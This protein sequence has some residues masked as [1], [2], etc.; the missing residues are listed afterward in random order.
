MKNEPKYFH[1]NE[2]LVIT[3]NESIET[4][5]Q[6]LQN[7]AEFEKEYQ[8]DDRPEPQPKKTNVFLVLSEGVVCIGGGEIFSKEKKST[9]RKRF[10]VCTPSGVPERFK[11]LLEVPVRDK[12]H[13]VYRKGSTRP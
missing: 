9:H 7:K 1:L 6:L 8:P 12:H 2:K 4:E 5:M 3:A 11:H 13:S 10:A